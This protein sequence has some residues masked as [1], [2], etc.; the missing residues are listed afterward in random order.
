LYGKVTQHVLKQLDQR[1]KKI[2]KLENKFKVNLMA[3]GTDF[4][5]SYKFYSHM[6]MTTTAPHRL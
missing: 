1:E 2:G 4:I 6:I 3:I 5:G